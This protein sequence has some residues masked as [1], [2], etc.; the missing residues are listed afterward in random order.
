MSL[1]LGA[2][3][4]VSVNPTAAAAQPS[5][6]IAT[7]TGST[8]VVL[9]CY[10]GSFVS[11][12]DSQGNAWVQIGTE[13]TVNGLLA[14]AFRCENITGNP[15]HIFTVTLS[16][17]GN[18]LSFWVVE[19]TGAASASIDGETMGVDTVTPYESSGITTTQADVMLIAI[20][21]E[22]AV[23]A[24]YTHTCGNSFTPITADAVTDANSLI[25]GISSYRIVSATGTYNTS[26]TISPSGTISAATVLVAIKEAVGG[27]APSGPA[28]FSGRRMCQLNYS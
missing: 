15:A 11:F 3:T 10:T 1:G 9:A 13:Q 23:S 25:T 22:D 28:P 19:S 27:G 20:S 18:I 2:H 21:A 7:T 5:S 4:S 24:V 17:G 8:V 12:A 6:A 16:S 14:R 26:V